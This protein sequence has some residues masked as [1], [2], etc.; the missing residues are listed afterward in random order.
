MFSMSPQPAQPPSPRDR[1]QNRPSG[2]QGWPR[3]TI[4]VRLGLALASF[5]LPGLFNDK[6][7][8]DLTYSEVVDGARKDRVASLK[9]NN[10]TG[11]ISGKFTEKAG[12]DDFRSH[13][14][15]PIPDGDLQTFREHDVEVTFDT[16]GGGF[17]ETW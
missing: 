9:W 2:P 14:P 5:T 4:W 15:V 8:K 16:P 12:G 3:W 17:L 11:S 1:S 7:T 10:D 13:G 6:G